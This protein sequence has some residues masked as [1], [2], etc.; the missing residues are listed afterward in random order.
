M[1][2]SVV[3]LRSGFRRPVLLAGWQ[4]WPDV[5]GRIPAGW[6]ECCGAEV[7]DEARLCLRCKR[8]TED[9]VCEQ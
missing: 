7:F 2:I 5:Q 3:Y 8:R 9:D 6:C 4:Y 1:P